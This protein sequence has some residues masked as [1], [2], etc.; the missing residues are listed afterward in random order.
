M[1]GRR[2]VGQSANPTFWDIEVA[3]EVCVD[4][5]RICNSA[6]EFSVILVLV[7]ADDKGKKRHFG[8]ANSSVQCMN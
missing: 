7:N 2:L 3:S 4:R 6:R 8:L 5:I 1:A